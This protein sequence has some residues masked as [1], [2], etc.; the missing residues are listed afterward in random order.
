MSLEGNAKAT[1]ELRGKLGGVFSNVIDNTLTLEGASADAKAT[2]D[3]IALAKSEAI[4]YADG[5]TAEDV[6]A[7]PAGFGLGEVCKIL[8]DLNTCITNGWY[9]TSKDTAHCPSELAYASVFVQTRTSSQI[10][11][12]LTS[13]MD[14]GVGILAKL[15]RFSNDGGA[16]WIEEWVNPPMISGEEYR[17]TERNN[18]EVVY[19]KRVPYTVPSGGIG[20]TSTSTSIEIPHGISN[21]GHI[22]R[23]VARS[24]SYVLPSMTTAGGITSVKTVNGTNIL[25]MVHKD[26]WSGTIFF[27]LY[28]TKDA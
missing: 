9:R 3:A 26:T 13:A 14:N 15:I 11:Q 27:K 2:G 21:F 17:T 24:G 1:H 28:Y 25:L 23:C 8:S 19:A 10:I 5:L 7:A 6:G 16:T 4:E 22:V 12:T 20:S 18:G